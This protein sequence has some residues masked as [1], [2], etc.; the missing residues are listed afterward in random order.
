MNRSLHL[1]MR[2]ICLTLCLV[3]LLSVVRPVAAEETTLQEQPVAQTMTTVVYQRATAGSA[4]IGQLENGAVVTVLKELRDFYQVDCYDTVGYIAKS[5]IVHRDEKFYVNCDPE[6]KH[7]RWMTYTA[8]AEALALRHSL[9]ALAERQRG[10]RYVLGGSRPGAFDC[11]GLT[12][13]LYGK[14]SIDLHRTA[15]QQLQDGIVVSREGVQVGDLIFFREPGTITAASHVGIYVG[16]NKMIH[17]AS[18]G[19][20]LTDLD[21]GYYLRN[22]LCARRIVNVAAAQLEQPVAAIRSTG[23]LATNGV[24]G[25]TVN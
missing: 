11:S 23:I 19:V 5:Q 9:T 17:S 10:S 24:S 14:H 8:P 25:R 18:A 15:S 6:S 22:Y 2:M 7:T 4:P 20:I 3:S 13:Y 21:E 12:Y 1:G 16:N